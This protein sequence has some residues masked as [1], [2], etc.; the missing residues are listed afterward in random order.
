MNGFVLDAVKYSCKVSRSLE[1]FFQTQY[2]TA[3]FPTQLPSP[4]PKQSFQF[5]PSQ[6]DLQPG[7]TSSQ[8]SVAFLLD[9]P[10][11]SHFSEAFQF[12]QEKNPNFF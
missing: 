4:E 11:D 7:F 3:R 5:Q 1:Q 10:V 9:D 12:S 6:E 2:P 8:N